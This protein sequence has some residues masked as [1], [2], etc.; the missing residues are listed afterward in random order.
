MGV[1]FHFLNVGDGDCT[2][3]DFPERIV[4]G[5][6]AEM[7]A[8]IMMVDIYHREDH[9]DYEHV[10]DYYKNNFKNKPIFRFIST[11]PHKDHLLGIKNLFEE[12]GISII[13][14]WDL[15]HNFEPLKEGEDW[16]SYKEDWDKYSK[17]RLM[18][19]ND[20]LC[21]RRYWDYQK[22]ILY[23]NE[24]NI[25]ILSPSK[26]LHKIAH[27]NEDGTNRKCH[28]IELNNMPYVLLININ[29]LKILLASDAED[30][31]WEYILKNHGNKIANTDILKAAHHG[32]LTGLHEEVISIM[33]P[34]N[35]IFSCTHNTDTECGAEKEYKKIVPNA[36]FY[37]TCDCG[38]I[39]INCDFDGNIK[40]L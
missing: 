31:C 30:K 13:N 15:E 21:V 28:E 10:I 20:G 3:V 11:H 5:T 1:I 8:R 29:D 12:R 34:K 17:I 24:D 38:T 33:K 18:S 26:E 6:K 27:Q 4:K 22:D 14:F 32:R 7:N 37:K 9:D 36:K 39:V 2:I 19:D 23:W 16:E 40:Q 25:Q 35:I